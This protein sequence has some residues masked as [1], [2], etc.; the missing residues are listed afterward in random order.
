MYTKTKIP[1]LNVKP[2]IS[3]QIQAGLSLASHRLQEVLPRCEKKVASVNIHVIPPSNSQSVSE[4]WSW[5]SVQSVPNPSNALVVTFNFLQN[6]GYM[7]WSL[8]GGKNN[9]NQLPRQ[10]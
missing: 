3:I 8:K 2:P 6:V 4:T 1:F 9:N 7:P 5:K 10:Q